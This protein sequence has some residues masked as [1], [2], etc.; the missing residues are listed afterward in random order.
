MNNQE[1]LGN[2]KSSFKTYLEVKTSRSTAKLKTLHGEI[3]RDLKGIFGEEFS[4]HAQGYEDGH[5]S[6]IDGRYYSKRVDITIKRRGVAVAG[7]AVKFVMRNYAQNSN[8]YF[9]NMLGET[10]NIRS[11]AVPYFQIFIILDKVPY[12]DKDGK[13]KRYDKITAHNLS[14]YL[15]LSA[16]NPAVFFH[17][18]DKTLVII[19]KIK[20]KSEGVFEDEN[21]YAEYYL[22]K[23][24]DR[25][26][27]EYAS[28]QGD[29][30]DDGVI[31]NDYEDFIRR[32]YYIVQGKLKG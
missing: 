11:N 26:L 15:S 6:S 27:L 2:V 4:V 24:D 21:E 16:D 19:A 22:S 28:L 18:P 8:N 7:Y 5:E 10:A 13:F 31:Y 30:F 25:D 23:I 3:A 1:F 17:T 14:K 20:D 9:E 29:P 32:T 12:Y